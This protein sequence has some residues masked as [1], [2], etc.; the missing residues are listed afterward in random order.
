MMRRHVKLAIRP[1]IA[2]AHRTFVLDVTAGKIVFAI[3]QSNFRL[4]NHFGF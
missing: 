4:D 3:A 2:K 1:G